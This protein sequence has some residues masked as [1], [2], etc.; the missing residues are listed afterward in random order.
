MSSHEEGSYYKRYCGAARRFELIGGLIA[1]VGI[2]L[3]LI[4]G[5]GMNS[6]GLL[7]VMIGLCVFAIGAASLRPNNAV[8]SFARQCVQQPTDE[9]AQGL[10][11]ALE[12]TPKL[13]LV[14][15]SIDLVHNAVDLYTQFDDAD[16]QL[17]A[18]L[19][20]AVENRIVTK[21]F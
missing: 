7:L 11:D 4:V 15:S 14:A 18:R 5:V 19:K 2:V 6:F 13:P 1:A 9:F 20:E 3:R 8:K 10:L 16:P 21:R 12:S 17:A